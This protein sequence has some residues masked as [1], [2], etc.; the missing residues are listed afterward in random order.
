MP[1]M[2]GFEVFQQLKADPALRDIPVIFIS[3]RHEVSE[4]VKAFEAS[5]VDWNCGCSC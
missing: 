5:G 3:A 2:S 1:K 4:K